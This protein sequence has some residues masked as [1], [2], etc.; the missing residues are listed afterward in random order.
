MKSPCV[1]MA[2][3]AAI[4]ALPFSAMLAQDLSP[5]AYIITPTHS[6]AIKLAYSYF[7]GGLNFNGTVPTSIPLPR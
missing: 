7:D 6:N 3:Y 1:S 5:R 4:S 2:W